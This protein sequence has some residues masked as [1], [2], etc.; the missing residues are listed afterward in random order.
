VSLPNGF[1]LT[2]VTSNIQGYF[3]T[4]KCL[5]G[6]WSKTNGSFGAVRVDVIS[7]I[8]VPHHNDDVVDG[9]VRTGSLDILL[10]ISATIGG[11]GGSEYEG[12]ISIGGGG[13]II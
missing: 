3:F 6:R 8:V 12:Y 10:T 9:V 13:G 7:V 4:K 5:S 1:I 2:S 11:S